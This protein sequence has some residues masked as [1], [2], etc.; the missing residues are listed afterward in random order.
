MN[1]R[2]IKRRIK[3][4]ENTRQITRAMEMVAATKMRKAQQAVTGTRDYAARAQQLLASVS[5]EAAP[6]HI[7]SQPLLE[8]RPV[9]KTA[10]V[11][12]GSDRGLCGALNTNVVKAALE[13]T[14]GSAS[15]VT[16]GRKSEQALRG[17]PLAASFK[18]L[19]DLSEYREILPIAGVLIDEFTAGN[20]D[21]IVLVYPEFVSTLVNKPRVETLLPAELPED[22]P[23]QT[24]ASAQTLYEPSAEAVLESLLPRLLEIRLY[25]ALLE[26]KASEHSAR[27]MAMRNASNNAGDL[28][29]ELR[30]SYNQA[31][32]AAITQE[33][34]EI[35][36]ASAPA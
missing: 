30:F 21:K 8:K 26:T 34:A 1:T 2:D 20:V 24:A 12:V 16:V 7:Q 36:A 10:F 9:K 6:E 17:Q 35:S 14:D 33:I 32:Q 4:I 27:M 31:R 19:G 5:A 29:E 23:K 15:F 13:A 18:G 25:Q 22:A 28:L 11:V 3:S